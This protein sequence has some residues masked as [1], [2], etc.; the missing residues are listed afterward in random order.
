MALDKK[1]LS[2]IYPIFNQSKVPTHAGCSNSV[3]RLNAD[4]NLQQF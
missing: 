2:L 1:T 4:K 3:S